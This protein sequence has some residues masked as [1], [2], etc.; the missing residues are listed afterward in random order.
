MVWWTVE[1]GLCCE[2]DEIKAWGGAILSSY[3]ELLVF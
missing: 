3:G 2:G 1:W